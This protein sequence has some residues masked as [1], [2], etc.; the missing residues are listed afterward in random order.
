MSELDLDAIE[1]RA[2]AKRANAALLV[3]PG[4][5]SREDFQDIENTLALVDA[6]R[7]ARAENVEYR[8]YSMAGKIAIGVGFAPPGAKWLSD[9]EWTPEQF[10]EAEAMIDAHPEWLDDEAPS[11]GVG[12]GAEPGA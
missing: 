12:G 1:A 8:R 6:L 4:Y 9:E 11:R 2:R 3:A 5:L 10:A 7:R